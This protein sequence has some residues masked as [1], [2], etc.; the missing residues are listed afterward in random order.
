[1]HV[2]GIL[3]VILGARWEAWVLCIVLYWVRMFFITGAYHRYFSHRTYKTSRW[4]QF[5]LAFMAETSAQR[6][7]IWW[8]AKHRDH[9]K[10]SDGDRDPHSPI[11]W[12]FVH[13]QMGWLFDHNGDTDYA[14]AKDLSK[15]PE[16]VLLNKMWLVPPSIMGVLCWM[17]LGF[18]GLLVGF[19]FSTVVVWHGTFTIN[20]L[21]HLWGKR[22]YKTEDTS[23]NNL[24]LALL[25]MG[26][27]W[28]NNHHH[29]M[30]STRQGFFW[31]EIDMT[32]YILKAMSWVGLVWDL[33]EPP[34]KV[35]ADAK[36]LPE[37]EAPDAA[38]VD[39][40]A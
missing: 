10:Y 13:A 32:Y 38:A 9:H 2:F 23:R 8:A 39:A 3:G 33:K 22:R 7:V 36:G 11:R 14:R 19:L 30:N 12:G 25:T 29:F 28:H 6:G 17:F 24:W 5:I 27:G 4:M 26:E 1:V 37:S 16:L 31:W 20:S 21:A 18:D 35:Y 15:Y 40:A 34:A